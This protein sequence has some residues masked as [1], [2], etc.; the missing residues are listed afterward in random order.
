MCECSAYLCVRVPL[1][2]SPCGYQDIRCPGGGVTDDW[3][4]MLNTEPG[5]S[6]RAV[7][8]VA[9]SLASSF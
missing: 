3:L 2:R 9:I 8:A 1:V 6:A 7:G 5:S 4:C